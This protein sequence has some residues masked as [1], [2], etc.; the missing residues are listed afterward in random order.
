[1]PIA[2]AIKAMTTCHVIFEFSNKLRKRSETRTTA[3]TLRLEKN[4]VVLNIFACA[5]DI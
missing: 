1:M 5:D 4:R 3:E 2:K